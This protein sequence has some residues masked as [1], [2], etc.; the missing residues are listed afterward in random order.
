M[1]SSIPINT[2]IDICEYSETRS[3]ETRYSI[4]NQLTKYGL[5]VRICKR[6]EKSLQITVII[7]YEEL[8]NAAFEIFKHKLNY[9]IR[10]LEL[11]DVKISK[12]T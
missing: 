5:Q 7:S 9:T 1:H 12:N 2:I 11:A 4:T 6:N 10:E 3:K 8:A